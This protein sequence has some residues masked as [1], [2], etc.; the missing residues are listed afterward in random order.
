VQT[1]VQQQAPTTDTLPH[2]AMTIKLLGPTTSSSLPCVIT[3]H[4]P[5]QGS[6]AG[7]A[8]TSAPQS[9]WPSVWPSAV[10][11]QYSWLSPA[12]TARRAAQR[13]RHSP[14]SAR[15]GSTAL[16]SCVPTLK[17]NAEHWAA[18]HTEPFHKQGRPNTNTNTSKM[19]TLLTLALAAL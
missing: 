12:G 5:S 4:S 11:R 17:E 6:V 14:R 2:L 3:H 16:Q 8:L 15:A 18:R 7:G 13:L 19:T 9:T 1:N 10:S